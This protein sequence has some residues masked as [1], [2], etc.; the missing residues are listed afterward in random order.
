MVGKDRNPPSAETT[1][2]DDGSGRPLPL[3]SDCGDDPSRHPF[4]NRE[5]RG[6]QPVLSFKAKNKNITTLGSQGSG[7][8]LV[9]E[10]GGSVNSIFNF[11]IFKK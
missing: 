2:V 5:G 3:S 4:R 11:R 9:T 1:T 6:S 10:S 8:L 7:R